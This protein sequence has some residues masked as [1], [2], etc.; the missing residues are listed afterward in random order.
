M[1]VCKNSQEHN[2]TKKPAKRTTRLKMALKL[3]LYFARQLV[4]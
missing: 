2:F 3:N 4:W 1:Q